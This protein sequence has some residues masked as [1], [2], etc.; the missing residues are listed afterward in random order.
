MTMK[1]LKMLGLVAIAAAVLTALAAAGS[2]QA[3]VLCTSKETPGCTEAHTYFTSTELHLS[4]ESG[5]SMRFTTGT[6]TITTCT[7]STIKGKTANK[8]SST[9]AVK[10]EVEEIAWLG[11]G[12]T[13]DTIKKGQLSIQWIKGTHSAAV[14]DTATELTLSISGSSCVYGF[15]ENAYIGTLT[16]GAEPTLKI[17]T[18]IK[19]ISG[20]CAG[21]ISL[22]DDLVVTAPH[23]LYVVGETGAA[24]EGEGVLCK[25]TAKPCPN[26]YVQGTA[27]DT[28]LSGSAVFESGGSTVAT[29]S[30]GTLKG[31]TENSGR[32]REPVSV[33]LETLT[34]SGCSQTTTTVTKG[35]LEIRRIEGSEN[36]TVIGESTQVTLGILGTSCTYGFGE[37]SD[38]GTLTSGESPVIDISTEL[39]K[40][41]G[42]LTC[43]ASV[44]WTAE[45]KLTELSPLYIETTE[46]GV[47]C[48]STTTPCEYPYEKELEVDAD[49]GGGFI[50]KSGGS[51]YGT[52]TGGTMKGNI[53]TLGGEAEAFTV[54][55]E[56]LT[57]TGCI[58]P[59]K[60]VSLGELEIERIAG[61]ENGTV[62]AQAMEVTVA[63]VLPTYDCTYGF[64]E[65]TD[66]GTFTGETQ[67]V[68]LSAT[69][70][71]TS[72]TFICPPTATWEAGYKLTK[73]APLYLEPL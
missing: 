21:E 15:G 31:N 52:C 2:A 7:G 12:Q 70:T 4:L 48:K 22:D 45:Y 60:T 32:S 72:G 1:Q 9:E 38:L 44:K 69:A 5:A 6:T 58:G 14:K 67:V 39:P 28:D 16:G 13:V 26:A 33:A 3:T 55:L 35:S 73:P 50:L 18:A 63:G 65:K 34:W 59:T 47:L 66:V 30:G 42:G 20:S 40:T 68:N 57:W 24:Y 11:C 64:V 46:E 8:G 51:T 62:S 23:A 49:A 53:P 61:T 29:C 41:S 37:E 43:P 71:R 27:I 10:L 25:E 17:N 54:S 19:K 56:E 36:G